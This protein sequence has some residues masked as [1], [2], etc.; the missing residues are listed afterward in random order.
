MLLKHLHMIQPLIYFSLPYSMG[1]LGIDFDSDEFNNQ[2]P[3]YGYGAW[4][5][6]LDSG[7]FSTM[8]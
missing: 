4:A 6:Y 3:E 7:W 8:F 2:Y 5:Y 1:D